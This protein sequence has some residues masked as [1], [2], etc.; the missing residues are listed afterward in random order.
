VDNKGNIRLSA[1]DLPAPV[2]AHV[3][4]GDTITPS[5]ALVLGSEI[6]VWEDSLRAG[7]RIFDFSGIVDLTVSRRSD[8]TIVEFF[9]SSD[10]SRARM[11][12][13]QGSIIHGL[14]P[15]QVP[16]DQ[17]VRGHVVSF[18][19]DVSILGEVNKDVI[20]IL[21]SAVVSPGAVV[22]GAVVSFSREPTVLPQARVYGR[23]LSPR[24]R[25]THRFRLWSRD[26]EFRI[27]PDVRYDR[28]DGLDLFMGFAFQDH[29]SILPSFWAKGG[30]AFESERWR[31][32]FGV[33]QTVRRAPAIVVGGE[34]FRRLASDDDWLLS[35]YENLAY[36]V[37]A[38]E[39][40]KDY[41]ESEGGLL[42]V[43]IKP[44]HRLS[45][46][47]EFRVETTRWLDAH[48][49]LWALFGGHKRFRD[50]F[51][52]VEPTFRDV[53][54]Q[55]IE[56]KTLAGPAF[57]ITWDTRPT[58]R[59]FDSSGWAVN[60]QL[61]WSVKD[62]SSDFDFRRYSIGMTRFQKIHRESIVLLRALFANSDG[63]LPMHR[64]FYLGGLGTL[65]G[66]GHKELIGTRF[67]MA[68]V[69]Y[70]LTIPGSDFA[71]AAIWDVGQIANDA[72]LNGDVEV[73]H[74]IGLA[75]DL[76][77]YFRLCVSKRLDR[78]VNDAPKFYARLTYPF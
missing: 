67:W 32:R 25:Q 19:G 62:W 13:R 55:D 64:R 52:T 72:P 31:Y 74:S 58:E 60:G 56:G 36:V 37:L 46:E 30:Y 48:P 28:V 20:S 40:F 16:V 61:E 63:Y 49:R 23:I 3:T 51:S 5:N 1:P 35:D 78:S 76:G 73:K 2:T 69:E 65:Q 9:T 12:L 44:L 11:R 27:D 7:N 29:D 41:Y 66:Y 6:T 54:K 45:V 10:T 59:I 50:N 33:E 18:A 15:V 68:N 70:R 47:A 34:A 21:G 22:R 24:Q 39:D 43:K 8:T 4:L 38:R 17:F 57:S 26:R 75:G 53:G 71:L 42:Y 77:S 14:S